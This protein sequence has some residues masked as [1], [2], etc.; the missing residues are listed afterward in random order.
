[1]KLADRSR[2]TS[3]MRV[4]CLLLVVACGGS[5]PATQIGAG[6]GSGSAEPKGPVKDTRSELERR[7]DTACESVGSRTT[8]C[9]LADAKAALAAGKVS[10]KEFDTST[11]PDILRKNTDEFVKKCRSG[12]MSSRQVRVLEVC[13]KEET[14]CGPF[15][16][17]LT[18][19]EDKPGK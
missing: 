12:Y 11:T 1:M 14:A 4:V 16:D 17:C 9:A 15:F 3:A 2:V 7:R 10:K 19:L 13:F 6:S 8:E 5:K 18:H